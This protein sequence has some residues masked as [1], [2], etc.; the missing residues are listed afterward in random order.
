MQWSS[1]PV[2]LLG[3]GATGAKIQSLLKLGVPILTS[4]QA[5]DLIDNS[6]EM[7]FGSPG[8]YGQRVANK[9]LHNA[10][11]VLAIG[12][13]CSIWNVG[14]EGIRPDQRLVMV[15]LDESEV[16]KFAHAEWIQQDAKDFIEELKTPFRGEWTVRCSGW[17]AGKPL[18][19]SP[20]HDDNEYINSYRFTQ[21]LQKYLKPDEVIVTDMGTALICA[22]QVLEL[23]P[24][25]RIM[26]SGGLGEMGCALPAAVGASFARDK[27]EVLCLTTDG[28]MMLN[29][30]ELQTI[31]H[32]QLPVRIIVFNNSG[33]LMIRHTQTTGKMR[34]SGVN[35][36]TGVSFPNYRHVAGAFGITACEVR[37][38]DD[39]KRIVPSFMSKPGPSLLEFHMDPKQRLV[40]KLDPVYID[41][42]ATSPAFEDMSP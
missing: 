2:I 24:P 17:R 34:L 41:G 1:R 12:N 9:A 40:P 31:V 30:Q 19:E 15:D 36:R 5:K 42:K 21:E 35:E 4:W 16:R 23:K 13:R 28:G 8:I 37:D 7:Y 10:D 27:G 38:W 14:Y 11:M 20:A 29:L 25:Q 22:H 33:Y 39:F 26:T 32:H 3:H 18:V 6:C